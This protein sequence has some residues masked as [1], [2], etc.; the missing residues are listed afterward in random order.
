MQAN[1]LPHVSSDGLQGVFF[2]LFVFRA[3]PGR[4]FCQ[5]Y[6][7]LCQKVRSIEADNVDLIIMNP[8]QLQRTIC[9]NSK[10]CQRGKSVY[11]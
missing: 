9:Q 6:S 8:A 3:L 1:E 11:Y 2:V 10:I 5:H 7:A 4:R